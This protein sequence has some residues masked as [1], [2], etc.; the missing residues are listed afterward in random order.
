MPNQTSHRRNRSF[1]WLLPF[2]GTTLLLSAPS[3][4]DLASIAI[5]LSQNTNNNSDPI[6]A[7]PADGSIFVAFRNG[8]ADA[9]IDVD[10]YVSSEPLSQVPDDLFTPDNLSLAGIGLGSNG[11]L[12]PGVQ[13]IVEVTCA[14]GLTLGT[15]GGTFIDPETGE[16]LGFGTQRWVMQGAQFD[17]GETIV[18]EYRHNGDAYSTALGFGF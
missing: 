8:T 9:A 3:G 5:E 7:N 1:V 12:G 17:C 13:D 18:F 15:T 16:E 6:A 4:C 10:F 14:D 11:R 2:F